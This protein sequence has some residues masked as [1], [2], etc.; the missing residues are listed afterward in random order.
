MVVWLY[1]FT[2]LSQLFLSND[3]AKNKVLL[4][5]YSIR[6]NKRISVFRLTG[7]KILGRVGTHIFLFFFLFWNC[8]NFMHFE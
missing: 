3:Q 5:A 7:L 6:L 2:L 1:V 8:F 4:F